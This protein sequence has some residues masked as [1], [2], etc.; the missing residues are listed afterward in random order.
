[1]P[2]RSL[3]FN[4]VEKCGDGRCP[5]QSQE[6]QPEVIRENE[7]RRREQ[8]TG[9][10]T[11]AQIRQHRFYALTERKR[12]IFH[13]GTLKEAAGEQ[14]ERHQAYAIG[15]RPEMQFDQR[16][17]TPF[18][19]DQSRHDVVHRTENHHGEKCVETE[20]RVRDA[21]LRE[22]DIARD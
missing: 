10:A 2:S 13:A 20:M 12:G 14:H 5:A 19:A 17:V 6:H 1:V 3:G 7:V 18:A 11:P 15:R 16:R 4:R 8:K 21:R 22:V 9:E